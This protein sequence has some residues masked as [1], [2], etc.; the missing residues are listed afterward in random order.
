MLSR[1]LIVM[2]LVIALALLVRTAVDTRLAPEFW[3]LG[4]FKPLSVTPT[5]VKPEQLVALPLVL[6]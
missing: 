6:K 1:N 3:R 2:F 4:R 5:N